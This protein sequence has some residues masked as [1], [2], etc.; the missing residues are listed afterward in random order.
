MFA[1]AVISSLPGNRPVDALPNDIW[2][3]M[4]FGASNRSSNDHP[5][6]CTDP[7]LTTGNPF[8][9]LLPKRVI[10]HF[11]CLTLEVRIRIYTYNFNN[12]NR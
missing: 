1:D 2:R 11:H 5:S 6:L 8:H 12:N 7:T 9:H 4:L 10:F 3:P